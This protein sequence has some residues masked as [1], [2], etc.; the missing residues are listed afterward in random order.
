MDSLLYNIDDIV[1]ELENMYAHI[2]KDESIPSE[3]L[4]DH[5]DLVVKQVYLFDKHNNFF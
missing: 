4:K 2:S 3:K 1:D 5:L